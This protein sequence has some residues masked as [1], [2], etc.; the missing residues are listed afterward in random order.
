[1]LG[2]FCEEKLEES[3]SFSLFNRLNSLFL[4]LLSFCSGCFGLL[5]SLGFIKVI[6]LIVV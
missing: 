6:I 5:F 2:I 3:S 4:L 1:M